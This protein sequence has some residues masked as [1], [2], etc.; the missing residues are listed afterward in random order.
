[1]GALAAATAAG[2]AEGRHPEAPFHEVLGGV[3]VSRNLDPL[4]RVICLALALAFLAAACAS[5][6]G[7]QP[8]QE[9]VPHIS[10][11]PPSFY[12]NDPQLRHWYTY[13]Y[14]NPDHLW[15]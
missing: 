9:Y 14:W 3:E 5:P 2:A 13:P 6:G 4:E 8:P 7:S 1:M 10:D 15:F 11:V 12:D